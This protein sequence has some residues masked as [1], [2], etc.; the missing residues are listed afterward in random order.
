[1][2]GADVMRLNDRERDVG[3]E[4]REREQTR[5]RK[6]PHAKAQRRKAGRDAGSIVPTLFATAFISNDIEAARRPART[7]LSRYGAMPYYGNMLAN[8]GFEEE[9]AGIRAAAAYG[10]ALAREE[11]VPLDPRG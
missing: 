4:T 5:D 8:A 10:A 9:I 3:D 1:M 11:L 6:K 2:R 7:L